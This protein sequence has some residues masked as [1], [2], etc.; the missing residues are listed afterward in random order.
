M[1]RRI[2][3]R[4]LGSVAGADPSSFYH[5]GRR[6]VELTKTLLTVGVIKVSL[7]MALKVGALVVLIASTAVVAGVPLDNP[8]FDVFSVY[9]LFS[10]VTSGMPEPDEKSSF[11]YIWMYRSCHILAANGTTY[12][13]NKSK[14]GILNGELEE[15]RRQVRS[16]LSKQGEKEG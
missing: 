12:F 9:Y 1:R 14:W 2:G 11:G 10:A 16:F 8:W 6:G 15:E 3:M 5:L 7:A 13:A 4:T